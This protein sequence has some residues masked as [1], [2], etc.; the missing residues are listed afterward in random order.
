MIAEGE[1]YPLGNYKAQD[2]YVKEIIVDDPGEGYQNSTIED[3]EICGFDSNG[4]ITCVK[5]NNKAYRST[6]SL[7]IIGPGSGVVLRPIITTEIPQTDVVEVIDC[8][9]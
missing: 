7:N 4:G 1:G 3:F 2:F 8:V 6:P 5:P 9:T